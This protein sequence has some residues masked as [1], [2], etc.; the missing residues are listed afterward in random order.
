MSVE[1]VERFSEPV[2]IPR[3]RDVTVRKK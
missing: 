3:K 2:E 1:S